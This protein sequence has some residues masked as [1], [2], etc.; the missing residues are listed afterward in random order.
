MQSSTC[1]YDFQNGGQVY[2]D[3]LSLLFAN[4]QLSLCCSRYIRS[5]DSFDAV[6][7]LNVVHDMSEKLE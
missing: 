5:Y 1:I 6:I 2:P 7:L 4:R 3:P